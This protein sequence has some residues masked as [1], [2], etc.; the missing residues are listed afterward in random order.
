LYGNNI[1]RNIQQVTTDGDRQIY[2][3]I[4]IL[5]KNESSPWYGVK[6]MLY[7]FHLV[8]QSFDNDILNKE[9]REGIVYQVNN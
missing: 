3:P 6:Y 9:D 1:I 7:T 4:D 8:E 5:S 2:N